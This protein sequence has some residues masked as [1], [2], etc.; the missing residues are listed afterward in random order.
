EEKGEKEGGEG[1]P[2]SGVR[3]EQ[4]RWWDFGR[5]EGKCGGCCDGEE[6]RGRSGGE[7]VET[8]RLLWCAGNNSGCG[9]WVVSGGL[10]RERR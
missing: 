6:R 7:V 2:V 10:K 1:V 4:S 5:E 3:D 9:S 8:M